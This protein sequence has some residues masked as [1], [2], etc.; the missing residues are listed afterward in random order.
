MSAY[1]IDSE[2]FRDQFSTREMRDIFSDR[3]TVQAWLDVEVAL[4]D[5]EADLGIIP[6]KAADAIRAVSDA[7]TFD[8]ADM[9]RE[10]DRTSHPIV[11]LVRMIAEKCDD[12]L[13]QFVHWG[14]TTQDIIDTGMMLQIRDAEA[15]IATR[16]ETL[17]DALADTP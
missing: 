11:P 12:D 7:E 14:A 2:L 6:Q 9:K 10:M 3:R 5:A 13:G 15:V 4:A 8:L 17:A 1:V 16:L